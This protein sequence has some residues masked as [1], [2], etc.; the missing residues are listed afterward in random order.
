MDAPMF[1][2]YYAQ[3]TGNPRVGSQPDNPYSQLTR[4]SGY[5]LGVLGQV[6]HYGYLAAPMDPDV[7]RHGP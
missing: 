6:P 5:E 3:E 7:K 2:D 1:P 4:G